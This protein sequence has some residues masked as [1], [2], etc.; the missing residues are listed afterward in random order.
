M[1]DGG[2][3]RNTLKKPRGH[4]VTRTVTTKGGLTDDR[5]PKSSRLSS[6]DGYIRRTVDHTNFEVPSRQDDFRPSDPV[7]HEGSF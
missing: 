4:R 1:D 7:S 3:H 2:G 6:L 5:E